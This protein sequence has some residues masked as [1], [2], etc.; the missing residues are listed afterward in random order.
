MNDILQGRFEMQRGNFR[1]EADLHVPARGLTGI[2][3]HSGSGKTSLLRCLAGLERAE[4]GY[5]VVDGSVWQDESQGIFVPS[6]Q[7]QLAYVFQEPRLF[8]HLTVRKNLEYGMR[9]KNGSGSSRNFDQVIE[10]LGLQRLLSRKP[11][12]LSGG[13]QQRAAIG[14]ALLTDPKLLLMDEP[15]AALDI[16]R[17][18]EIMPF[19][20][21]LHNELDIPVILVSHSV[22]EITR[23]ADS[24]VVMSDGKISETGPLSQMLTY[25]H[26]YSMEGTAVTVT[27][28]V[29]TEFD[30]EH[31]IGRLKTSFGEL[32]ITDCHNCLG[33]TIRASIHAR[34]VS[35]CLTQ[36]EDTSI[37]NNISGKIK[38][39]VTHD[40]GLADV[41][42]D[43]NGFSLL[44]TITSRSCDNLK[45]KEGKKVYAQIKSV[46][47]SGHM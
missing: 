31:H 28:G 12:K 15:L 17:K 3:G 13:E 25:M 14:R 29:I 4:Q 39:I 35:L 44:S 47:L 21:R 2:F 45:L 6:Y 42:I 46:A 27:E 9:R 26:H 11:E 36:P 24:V 10:T 18:K 37:L 33:K 8:P 1:L 38:N 41:V 43:I 20:E 16:H 34:D 40:T 22:E 32:V 5:L 19:L 7:R 30:S 23:L